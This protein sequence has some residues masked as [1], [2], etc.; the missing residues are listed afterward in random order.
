MS[1]LV[2]HLDDLRGLLPPV[3]TAPDAHAFLERLSH[4]NTVAEAAATVDALVDD[5]L[6]APSE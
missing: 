1:D 2:P 6:T 4:A 5:W 3:D